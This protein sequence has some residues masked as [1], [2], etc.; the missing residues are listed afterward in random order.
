LTTGG[1]SLVQGA[2]GWLWAIHPQLVPIPGFKTVAQVKENL[3]ALQFGALP[4]TAMHE[5]KRILEGDA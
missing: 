2:L 1:R 5:I 3:E 4:Q